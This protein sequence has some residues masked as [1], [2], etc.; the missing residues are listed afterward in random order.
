MQWVMQSQARCANMHC[1]KRE[2]CRGEDNNCAAAGSH[3]RGA[4]VAQAAWRGGQPGAAHCVRSIRR[5]FLRAIDQRCHWE[6]ARFSSCKASNCV[7]SGIVRTHT[8][9]PASWQKGAMRFQALKPCDSSYSCTAPVHD[10]PQYLPVPSALA[11]SPT[12]QLHDLCHSGLCKQG[13]A[14]G[15]I[16]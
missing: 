9:P 16:G 12:I 15:G 5:R 7:Q 1:C 13:A 6:Q 14:G 3:P 4:A 8:H 11:P 2:V 10:V